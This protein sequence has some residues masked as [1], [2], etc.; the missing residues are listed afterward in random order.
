MLEIS[1]IYLT[2]MQVVYI[3][4]HCILSSVNYFVVTEE[5]VTF[6]KSAQ[7]WCINSYQ[8]E[9]EHINRIRHLVSSMDAIPLI[10]GIMQ[11]NYAMFNSPQKEGYPMNNK[12]KGQHAFSYGF[13]NW[14]CH[15]SHFRS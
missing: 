15:N 6:Q 3:L 13:S 14:A 9:Y 5:E 10:V 7:T 4:E 1:K 2:S 8:K 12:M 11:H